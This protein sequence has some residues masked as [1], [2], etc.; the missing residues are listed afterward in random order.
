MKELLV[1]ISVSLTLIG[2]AAGF[3]NTNMQVREACSW[4][5][6]KIDG[7]KPSR[8]KWNDEKKRCDCEWSYSHPKSQ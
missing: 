1:G 4:A 8:A 2:L 6:E 3:G 7:S 5:C